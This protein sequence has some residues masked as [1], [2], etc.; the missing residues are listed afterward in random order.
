MAI[1]AKEPKRVQIGNETYIIGVWDVD[2]ALKIFS[3]LTKRFGKGFMSLFLSDEGLQIIGGKAI[4]ID[5]DTEKKL[6]EDLLEKITDSLEPKEYVDYC[7]LILSGTMCEGNEINFSFHFMGR[8]LS[9]H[10]L[11]IEILTFQYSDFL[12]ESSGEGS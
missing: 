1:A 4:Q 10:K 9:L 5:T 3:W 6:L 12:G 11:M 7:K 2:K 8:I